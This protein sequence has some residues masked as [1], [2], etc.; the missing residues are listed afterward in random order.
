MNSQSPRSFNR[1]DIAG[2]GDDPL[3]LSQIISPNESI[4]LKKNGFSNI[5]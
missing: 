1:G 3:D 5:K 2:S 4:N